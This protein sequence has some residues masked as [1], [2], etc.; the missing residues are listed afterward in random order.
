[1]G[2]FLIFN[3]VTAQTMQ[4]EPGVLQ[5]PEQT[6][7]A[8]TLIRFQKFIANDQQRL[9]QM[10]S[11]SK[12]LTREID[13]LTS[14]FNNLDA[15]QE[16]AAAE[17]DG[18]N[19]LEKSRE[20]VLSALDLHLLSRQAIEQQIIIVQNKVEKQKEVVNYVTVGQ[21]VS[22]SQSSTESS[23]SPADT[24]EPSKPVSEMQN[25]KEQ[26]ALEDLQRLE[27]LLMHAKHNLLL[28]D[29]L[30]RLN[31]EDLEQAK[32]LAEASTSMRKLYE[33]QPQ[34]QGATR[35]LLENSRRIS[36]DTTLVYAL[37]IRINSL[38]NF[39]EP[40]VESVSI[41]EKK[42]EAARSH[43]QFLQSSIAP[44]RIAHWLKFNLPA[45]A[46]ILAV[47]LL[48]WIVS[49]WVVKLILSRMI[50][51]R[52]V[53][54]EDAGRLETLKLAS[55]SIITILIVFIGFLVLLSEIG[56]D[57]TVVLGGAAV[58]SLI[59]AF[60]AQSLVKDYFS[61]FM[62]LLENQYR[63]G[64]VVKINT[65]IG[66][67]E[68]MSLRLTVLRD[69][70]GISHFIPHGQ[71]LEVSNLTHGWSQVVFDIGVSYNEKVDTVMEV[72]KEL[73]AQ[74]K[75]DPE[76]GQL[77]IGD[78]DMLGVDKFE[79]SAIVIKFLVRTKPL[80]QWIVKRELLRRIKNRFDELGIEIPFPHLTV[81]HRT[82]EKSNFFSPQEV[83]ES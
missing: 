56:V 16:Q 48:I 75:E 82:T 81:Y 15:Q 71:V 46:L 43:L 29:Q 59:I 21:V 6:S 38:G 37:K 53:A 79:G 64:N 7:G 19:T 76:Y 44:H 31:R 26:E 8:E 62:I 80:K 54:E 22:N 39:R 68:N 32:A 55:S 50:K 13:A 5:D 57:L 9:I 28:V 34:A 83:V 14:E 70:E 33:M 20:Q 3:S 63:A 66:V 10:K 58:I 35:R 52:R 27:T 73:G 23:L 45:I 1:M 65:T 25:R 77:L 24:V 41:A 78:L 72:L 11:R 30:I 2:I 18:D 17:P 4:K 47:L 61:G 51:K 60:G 49:R 69:L 36:E 40:L 67:V 74:L 42:A 12:Q